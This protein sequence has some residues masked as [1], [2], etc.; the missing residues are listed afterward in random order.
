MKSFSDS[1]SEG[2]YGA[3]S[4]SLE[5]RINIDKV[6]ANGHLKQIRA[7][8]NAL[9]AILLISVT[10]YLILYSQ[11][12]NGPG[13][14]DLKILYEGGVVCTL[15]ALCLFGM[16]HRPKISLIIAISVYL[17]TILLEWLSGSPNFYLGLITRAI[18]SFFLIKGLIGSF[19]LSS[20]INSLKTLGVAEK[21]LLVVKKLK[22]IDIVKYITDREE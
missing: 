12:R 6:D 16:Y 15:Y 4:R 7:A 19:K 9:V 10:G 13:L 5:K 17:I 21:E 20:L 3:I 11:S 1:S 22:N 2:N 14:G 8:R 18:L